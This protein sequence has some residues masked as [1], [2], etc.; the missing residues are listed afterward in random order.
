MS[1]KKLV[2]SGNRPTGQLH[3]G[4]YFGAL[5]NWIEIQEKYDCYY[6]IADWHA[7]TTGYEHP[8]EIPPSVIEVMKD[9]LAC[10]L[11]PK[12]STIFIQSWVP[13]HSELHV[14]LSM[15]TPL[16]W[17]ERVPSFKDMREQLSDRDLNMY[18]FLGYPLL[19]TADIII[20]NADF[21]PVGEDQVAHIEFSRELVRR[22]HFL[23]KREGVF[24]EPKPLLTHAARVPGTDGRKMSKSFGNA[25]FIADEDDVIRKKMMNT[26]TDPA[27]KLRSDP[28]TPEVCNIY[29][30]HKLY[31]EKGQVEEIAKKCRAAEIGCVD[32]KKQCIENAIAFWKPIRAERAK[33]A[34]KEKK[35]LEIAREGSNKARAV[36]AKTMET[37]REVMGLR[38]K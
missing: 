16:G 19:Q 22:F 30:Y 38:Y 34:G 18:G 13:E 33:W 36:A 12:K 27:R 32:C 3:W 29:A 17:L 26:I 37:V 5:K 11:D 20:Y 15:I 21:V 35:L 4:N 24:V 23:M 6:F 2:V 7:L 31:T 28:G 14:L 25:I 1:N 9:W 10:G 8:E